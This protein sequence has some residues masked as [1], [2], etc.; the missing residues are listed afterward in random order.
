M[1]INQIYSKFFPSNDQA[2]LNS[3]N[4]EKKDWNSFKTLREE[5]QKPLSE[6]EIDCS[7]D[8]RTFFEKATQRGSALLR[9]VS[10][11]YLFY[12]CIKLPARLL[13]PGFLK[14]RFVRLVNLPS[15]V[16][17][18]SQS[19]SK[20]GGET[21]CQLL[22]SKAYRTTLVG[23]KILLPIIALRYILQRLLMIVLYPAQSRLMEKF[24]DSSLLK[25]NL[26][27][28]RLSATHWKSG[29]KCSYL[30]NDETK[31]WQEEQ[32][33]HSFNYVYRNLVFKQNDHLLNGIIISSE[34]N[35]GNGN[36][37]LQ[38]TGNGEPIENT[39]GNLINFYESMGLNLLMINGP[40]VGSSEGEAT[41][42]T[43]RNAQEMGLKFLEEAI[44]AKKIVIAGRSLGGAVIGEVI[45]KH[46]FKPEIQYL[47]IRLMSFSCFSNVVGYYFKKICQNFLPFCN[48]NSPLS[49]LLIWIGSRITTFLG[50]EIDGLAGS[51]SLLSQQ[52]IKE[53]IVQSGKGEGIKDLQ[54]MKNNIKYDGVIPIEHSLAWNLIEKGI[55]HNKEFRWDK[56]SSLG[57][58]NNGRHGS[59]EAYL[60]T[61]KDIKD[62]ISS[63]SEP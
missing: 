7:I 38:A 19:V 54:E 61:Q 13:I 33:D 40:G 20:Y 23:L 45:S 46:V 4:E 26:T 11:A 3:S 63:S 8:D 58:L 2:E 47:V 43:M 10:L 18:L 62:F 1:Y 17:I 59:F 55:I 36:W 24:G 22:T 50:L 49:F 14:E 42:E 44:H 39:F 12:M 25:E 52:S 16:E 57:D 53:V 9:K 15:V 35:M 29:T 6:R 27:R 37:V 32:S 51:Q 21:A 56:V 41:P 34:A 48:D 31:T 30:Y 60:E 28:N 5:I